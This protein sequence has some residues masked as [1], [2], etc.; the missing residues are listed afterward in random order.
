MML[1]KK[2]LV[3]GMLWAVAG[4]IEAED[5]SEAPLARGSATDSAPDGAGGALATS[6]AGGAGGGGVWHTGAGGVIAA[7]EGGSGAG[8]A[9]ATSAG[10]MTGAG[11]A[12]GVPEVTGAGGAAMPPS[13]SGGSIT[14]PTG[15]GGAGPLNITC[16]SSRGCFGGQVCYEGQCANINGARPITSITCEQSV[17]CDYGSPGITYDYFLAC[18]NGSDVC[19]ASKH[20]ACLE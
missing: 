15:A 9:V 12:T 17:D 16:V 6:S 1:M 20:C 5:H 10:G 7:G 2:L 8:G 4:C 18:R 11:G 13:G 14:P 19:D 3:V